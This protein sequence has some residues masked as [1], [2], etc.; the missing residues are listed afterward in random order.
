[1]I[2]LK[3]CF[4]LVL[5]FLYLFI[6]CA[7]R[8]NSTP[9]LQPTGYPYT[10]DSL[11]DNKLLS[12]A[13]SLFYYDRKKSSKLYR[14][15][16][17]MTKNDSIY[18]YTVF[19]I[20]LAENLYSQYSGCLPASK[21]QFSNSGSE[22]YVLLR[23]M[24]SVFQE[25][26]IDP[27]SLEIRL[28]NVNKSNY[29]V[30]LTHL[31]LA[32]NSKYYLQ[33]NEPALE[34]FKNAINHLQQSIPGR[35]MAAVACKEAIQTAI[36]CREYLLSRTLGE[37]ALNCIIE[38]PS[39]TMIS[40]LAFIASGYSRMSDTIPYSLQQYLR[41]HE[42]TSTSPYVYIDQE[43]LKYLSHY[44]Y[45]SNQK[46]KYLYYL[47]LYKRSAE[48]N[49]DAINVNKNLGQFAVMDKRWQEAVIFLEKA[50]AHYFKRK[51]PEITILYSICV[52]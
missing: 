44:S 12:T 1:M 16:L 33:E 8:Q 25:E 43:A 49:G 31:A 20:R 36:N 9:G 50:K 29:L 2:N 38:I 10:I 3:I 4:G 26:K 35:G 51:K 39:D 17:K 11:Y 46:E 23:Q 28:K 27:A 5:F 32:L 34:Y 19:Q 24:D 41:S 15:L 30:G 21:V 6:S 48:K 40:G 18:N 47:E 14:D 7:D 45:V 42:I 37:L 13:D 52:N 22:F